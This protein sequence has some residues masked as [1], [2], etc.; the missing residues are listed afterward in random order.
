[1]AS[2]TPAYGTDYKSGKAAK[3]AFKAGKDFVF[4]QIGHPD[5]GRY[6]NIQDL[7]GT[8]NHQLRFKNNTGVTIVKT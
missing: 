7:K 4:N 3:E 5:D 2:L 1:M 6:C 8:G